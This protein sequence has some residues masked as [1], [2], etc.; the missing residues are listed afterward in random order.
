[1]LKSSETWKLFVNE[2]RLFVREPM[3]IAFV[4][5]FPI[6]TVLVLGG[7]FDLAPPFLFDFI[8]PSEYYVAG[9]ISV[10]IASIGFVMMPVHIASY[11]ERG[12]IKRLKA[13]NISMVSFYIAQF[14]AGF[15]MTILS[16]IA[17]MIA[18]WLSYGIP[19]V[20]SYPGIIIG[21]IV[22][23]ATFI[24]IGI[25]LGNLAPTARSAQ[26]I[27][28]LVFF[29]SFL[30]SGAGPPPA[31]MTNI[32]SRISDVIPMTHSLRAVQEPWLGLGSSNDHLFFLVVTFTLTTL[33]W[34]RLI[35]R[36]SNE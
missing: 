9:Y 33:L 11:R 3:V 17:L 6:I 5:A 1:M 29:P 20:S 24:S 23:T 26:A 16:T 7:V 12:I 32:M 30:L 15:V 36:N 35:N 27:G 18:A 31:T 10:A 4:F 2:L 34:I 13:S 28:L 25:L 14:M 22:A 8:E 19:S 21:F